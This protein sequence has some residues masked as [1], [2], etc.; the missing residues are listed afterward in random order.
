MHYLE[1]AHEAQLH[2]EAYIALLDGLLQTI[3]AK[4]HFAQRVGITPQY[5]SYLLNPF[6]RTPSPEV[7]AFRRGDSLG[8]GPR[9]RREQ[10]FALKLK[11]THLDPSLLSLVM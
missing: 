8:T 1:L 5:L 9:T 6:D 4:R 11:Y 3:T 10:K 7:V 2:R